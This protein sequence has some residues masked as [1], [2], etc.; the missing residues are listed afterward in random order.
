MSRV[1]F[2]PNILGKWLSSQL[3]C[4]NASLSPWENSSFHMPANWTSFTWHSPSHSVSWFL[5]PR[6]LPPQHHCFPRQASSLLQ[7]AL[8]GWPPHL[9]PLHYHFCSLLFMSDVRLV[10]TELSLLSE[11]GTS[12][13]WTAWKE[14]LGGF[15]P[16]GEREAG[17]AWASSVAAALAQASWEPSKGSPGVAHSPT[18]VMKFHELKGISQQVWLLHM[19]H[20]PGREDI[21][22][23]N[24][25]LQ[26]SGA[27]P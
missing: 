6:S 17:S 20:A 16:A 15:S 13:T 1:S 24:Y 21:C 23:C 9:G 12:S 10:C 11:L 2:T 5:R 19:R 4:D 8:L 7:G 3:C 25:S 18:Q 26:L 22:F 27:R 14:P